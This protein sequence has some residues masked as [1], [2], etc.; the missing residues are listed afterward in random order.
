MKHFGS[1]KKTINELYRVPVSYRLVESYDDE[2]PM[3]NGYVLK[4]DIANR[5][6]FIYRPYIEEWTDMIEVLRI[7][8]VG[9]VVS[10]NNYP[11]V[12]ALVVSELTRHDI[13]FT[14]IFE[15]RDQIPDSIDFNN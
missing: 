12:L 3:T 4:E 15:G 5:N 13:S 2:W 9:I 10:S 1:N 8:N 11:D 7:D 6:Y 14:L